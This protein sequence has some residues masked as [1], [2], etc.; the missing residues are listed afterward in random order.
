MDGWK[1]KAGGLTL[2][3]TGA[4]MLL[5]GIAE[6]ITEV[7]SGT[8]IFQPGMQKVIEGGIAVGLGFASLG[9]GHKLDKNTEAVKST[10]NAVVEN[11]E[12]VKTDTSSTTLKLKAV[13]IGKEIK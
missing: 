5:T 9:I 2:M 7:V 10:T 11:T 1:T 4:A 6:L 8:L 13:G 12:A 3:A